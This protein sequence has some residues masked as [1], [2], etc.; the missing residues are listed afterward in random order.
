MTAPVT[1]SPLL[2]EPGL[3]ED[4]QR[5]WDEGQAEVDTRAAQRRKPAL[6]RMWNGD[7]VLRS[8]VAGEIDAEFKWV[9]NDTAAGHITLP[10]DHHL[11]EWVIGWRMRPKK[12]IHIT[13]DKDGARWSGRLSRLQVSKTSSGARE[14][15]LEFLHDYEELKHIRVWSNPVLPAAVQFP[16][17]FTLAGPSIW[18]LKT[19]LFL[20][21]MRLQNSLFTL[22]D[23]PLDL[24]QWGGNLNM[25]NW[26]IAMRG[27]SFLGDSSP[28]AIISSRFKTFH[29]LAEPILA[30]AQLMVTC[31]RWLTGDPQPWPGYTPRNGQLIVDIV[32][33]SGWWGTTGTGGNVLQGIL[34]T[35]MQLADDLVDIDRST[36]PDPNVAPVR[37]DWLGTAPGAPWVVYRDGA[38]GIE[39]SEF[40]WEP[41]TDVHMI[42]GG[43][44][45]PGVNELIS[46]AVQLAGDLASSTYIGPNV[47]LGQVADTILKPLYTDTLLAWMSFK[48]LARAQDLGWSHY[49]EHMPS[50]N[51][52][53]AYTLSSLMAI[54]QGWWETRERVG[55]KIK[56]A[57]GAPY[58]VGQNGH[59]H[60]WLGDRI[61]STI[62]GV[63]G[64]ELIV[65]QVSELVLGWNRERFGW[66][67]TLGDLQATQ[68][69]LEQILGKV[70][71][72]MEAAQTLGVL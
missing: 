55:H 57:D 21:L 20:N 19:A 10:W 18:G 37:G 28:H 29:E 71:G 6:T 66:E 8:R 2:D 48:S 13:V 61:A 65:D 9:L 12:N 69:G 50:G 30:D 68:S 4:L 70:R 14:L 62:P 22:P 3:L 23:D 53:R 15:R 38:P 52:D 33:R 46:S 58:L 64:G 25:A 45:M 1:H 34:R 49:F 11:R 47:N 67:V 44:S 63:P 39:S 16:R 59:G 56:I 26:P 60:F 31:D 32:D 42:V 40:S 5:I 41:A 24:G 36:V 27:G 51:A 35:A 72:A 7:W 17:A 43:K 54:R